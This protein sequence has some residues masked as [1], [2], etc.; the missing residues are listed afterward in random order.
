MRFNDH[1]FVAQET[2]RGDHV[3][4]Y[5]GQYEK[6]QQTDRIETTLYTNY[7]CQG[8]IKDHI[9]SIQKFILGCMKQP[10]ITCSRHL[11]LLFR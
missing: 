2:P 8:F 7:I 9:F 10:E 1:D 11:S 6:M 5:T 3:I 4:N